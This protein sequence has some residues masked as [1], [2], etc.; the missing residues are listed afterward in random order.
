MFVCG[1][2]SQFGVRSRYLEYLSAASM[3]RRQRFYDNISASVPKQPLATLL[4]RSASALSLALQHELDGLN[5]VHQLLKFCKFLLRQLFPTFRGWGAIAKAK[6]Q[7]PDLVEGE[8]NLTRSLER[9]QPVER[10]LVVSSLSADPV[11]G[12]KDANLFVVAN[13]GWPQPNPSRHLGNG[14]QGHN[15]ILRYLTLFAL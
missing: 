13:R 14:Q 12:K 6:E 15:R 5:P 7:L 9:R 1:L 8:T 3:I 2:N 4:K 11:S 10:G